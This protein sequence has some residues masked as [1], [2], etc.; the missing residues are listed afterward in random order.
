MNEKN[1]KILLRDLQFLVAE[2]KSEVYSDTE[3][4]LDSENVRR[5][6]IED[7]DGETD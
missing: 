5:V 6:R 7:D 1:V 3:S 4:Y 2:L